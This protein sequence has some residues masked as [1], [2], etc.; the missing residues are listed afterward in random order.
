M[1]CRLWLCHS[2]DSQMFDSFCAGFNPRVKWHGQS[3]SKHFS[4]Q[5]L[6]QHAPHFSATAPDDSNW[7]NQPGTYHN[8]GPWPGL[9]IPPCTHLVCRVFILQK[10]SG[11]VKV[12]KFMPF[13][14]HTRTHEHMHTRTHTP[15]P[16]PTH[17]HTHTHT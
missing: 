15:T 10:T 8:S 16:T 11:F 13:Y 6:F 7:A 9:R 1:H 3:V 14:K 12:C 2:M 4:Y 5:L 17:T